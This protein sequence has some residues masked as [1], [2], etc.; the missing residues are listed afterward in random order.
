MKLF[1]QLVSLGL[2]IVILMS[3]TVNVLADT[4]ENDTITITD[5]NA[6]DYEEHIAKIDLKKYNQFSY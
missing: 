4:A 2:V 6:F 5:E 3:F 1:K